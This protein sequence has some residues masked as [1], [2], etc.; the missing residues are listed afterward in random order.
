MKI[1][2]FA[3]GSGRRLWPISR[4]KSPKQFEPIIDKKSTLQL[5]VDRVLETYGAENIF[6]ST[7][8][9]YQTLVRS[10]LPELPPEQIIGEPDR[11]DLAAAVGLAM[12]HI[13]QSSPTAVD[14]PVAI[15]WG[16]N[17]MQHVTNF[18]QLLKSAEALVLNRTANIFFIGETPRYANEN[19]GWLGLGHKIS[20]QNGTPC[21]QFKSLTYRPEPAE[22]HRMF[23]DGRYVW[24]TGYFVTTPRYVRELYRQFQ[25]EIWSHLA[26]IEISIGSPDYEETLHRVYPQIQSISFDDAILTN[27]PAEDAAVLH[28]ELG[29]SDPGTLYALKE[30]IEPSRSRNVIKGSVVD[31]QL[32]DCLVY[33][34]TD[35][36]L[37]VAVGLEGMIIVNTE[38]ALLVVNK[39]HIPLVK[40]VVNDFEGTSLEA[41]S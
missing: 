41:F 1:I 6:V 8:E 26:A 17:Y 30:A 29:W 33:N 21:Y 36:K 23:E 34:Y 13:A 32:Q 9:R 3:G 25:P 19:L 37:V 2:I 15:L 24:N 7:N 16:D 14:E 20:N 40:E 4:V 11:R 27:V 12:A 5:A 22:C 18:R 31:K 28:G 39:D 35:K 10:Q 38:D